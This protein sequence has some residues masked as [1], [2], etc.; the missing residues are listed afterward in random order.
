MMNS[1]LTKM[2]GTSLMYMG[3]NKKN[4]PDDTLVSY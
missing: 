3:I 1:S 4:I 2:V